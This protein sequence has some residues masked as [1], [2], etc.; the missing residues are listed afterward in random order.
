MKF[1]EY[2]TDPLPF[3]PDLGRYFR[4]VDRLVVF[5]IGS[6][7]AEDAIRLKRRF[8][9]A[10]VYAFEPLPQNVETMRRN[11]TRFGMD[12]V[13]VV[14]V[15]L[16]DHD[17]TATFHV[18]SGRPDHVPEGEDWNYGNKSSSL[19]PPGLTKQV[20]PWLKFEQTITVETFRLDTFC[21]SHS[22]EFVDFAYIDVQGAELLVLAGAGDYL[23]R[24]GMIWM[25][26]EAV[27]L[28]ADQPLREEVEGFMRDHGFRRLRS[29]VGQIS[30]DQLYVNRSLASRSHLARAT[31]RL[32]RFWNRTHS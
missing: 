25:E 16:S 13:E 4:A 5:D 24:I 9:K 14:P 2:I 10:L 1:D 22:I 7:E 29:T 3:E 17:G 12:D 27:E 28:Y 19:L 32:A 11:L 18:S 6:C 23:D 31:K 30:G 20:L 26:V 15:A 8:P 21:R